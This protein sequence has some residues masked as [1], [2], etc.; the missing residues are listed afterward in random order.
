MKVKEKVSR[1]KQILSFNVFV[2]IVGSAAFA[3]Y[4]H[5]LYFQ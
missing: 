3:H 4:E 2:N 1:K 5:M